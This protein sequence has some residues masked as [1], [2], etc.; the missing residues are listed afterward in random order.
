MH[1]VVNE[2][3]T[4]CRPL[5]TAPSP[6]SATQIDTT[7]N[8]SFVPRIPKAFPPFPMTRYPR[9]LHEA[10]ELLNDGMRLKP[11]GCAVRASSSSSGP[12]RTARAPK[13]GEASRVHRARRCS[14]LVGTFSR[15]D[16]RRVT[17]VTHHG[18]SFYKSFRHFKKL[19]KICQSISSRKGAAP[20]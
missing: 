8:F 13:R 1:E 16:H 14:R 15:Q 19:G 3:A 20:V 18:H 7:T 9:T 5:S 6:Q 11:A 12:R 10:H 2:H 4:R 17:R